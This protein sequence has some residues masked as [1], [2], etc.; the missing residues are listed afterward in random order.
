M[1]DCNKAQLLELRSRKCV[2]FDT[3]S[4]MFEASLYFLKNP[5]EYA[6]KYR[7]VAGNAPCSPAEIQRYINLGQEELNIALHDQVNL[8]RVMDAEE[9]DLV[10]RI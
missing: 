9:A 8:I 4:A 3:L 5:E 7:A 2:E 1:E 10:K 6:N